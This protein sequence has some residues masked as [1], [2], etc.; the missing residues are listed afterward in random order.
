MPAAMTARLRPYAVVDVFTAERYGGNPLAVVLDGSGL[1]E[2]QMQR[3]AAWT[4]LSETAF[5]LPPTHPEADYRVRIYTPAT[6]LP[7]AGHP[8]LGSCQ[9]WLDQGGAPHDAECIVQECALGLVPIQRRGALLSFRAPALRR[10]PV[11]AALLAEVAQALGVA[12]SR[13][14]AAQHLDNGPHWL[15]LLLDDADTVL[16]LQPDHQRLRALGHKV[17]VAALTAQ[18]A[19]VTLIARGSREARAFAGHDGAG[20][21]HAEPDLQVRAFAAAVGVPE[22]PVTGSLQAALAQW[23]LHEGR[24]SAPYLAAQGQCLNRSARVLLQ[25]DAQG[26][27]WV[28]GEVQA[29]IRGSVPL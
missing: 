7:F 12:R 16:A 2:A 14:L 21:R 26:Q 11:D 29:A 19:G 15:A 23:L 5:L 17:G 13:I 28:G 25:C 18:T 6:E 10:H 9:A 27:V 20:W 8:T 1:S 4:N 3:F 24:L 22:D